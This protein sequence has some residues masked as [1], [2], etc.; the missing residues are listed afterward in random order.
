MNQRLLVKTIWIVTVFVV[1][2]CAVTLLVG[3]LD[4]LKPWSAGIGGI[5]GA[6]LLPWAFHFFDRR[7]PK[8]KAGWA[9]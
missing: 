9:E 7:W 8:P 3:I 6:L 2:V 4:T 1:A 5:M